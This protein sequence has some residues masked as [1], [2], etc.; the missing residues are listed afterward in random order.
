MMKSNRISR[1]LKHDQTL[2]AVVTAFGIVFRW[3]QYDILRYWKNQFVDLP[4]DSFYYF[5]IAKQIALGN[6][7]S[8]DGAHAT[9]GMH[10]L[11]LLLIAPFFATAPG[12]NF[13]DAIQRVVAFQLLL[14]AGLVW[15]IGDTIRLYL[16]NADP[17][18]RRSAF[19]IPALIYA[20]CSPFVNGLETTI[21]AL[22]LI[23]WLRHA[24][25]LTAHQPLR[26]WIVLGLLTG[27]LF[28]ARTDMVVVIL[29]VAL[30]ILIC[31]RREL[32]R[33]KSMT[34]AA[35]TLG[36]IAPWLIWNLIHFGT[37][38]QSSAEAVQL[39]AMRKYDVMYGPIGRYWQLLIEAIHNAP[40]PF[41]VTT[42]GFSAMTICFSAYLTRRNRDSGY[43]IFL[44]VLVGGILLLIVHSFFR[45]FIR[46]WYVQQL[47]PLFLIGFGVS[48][49]MNA[50]ISKV[51][52]VGRS[53]LA[54]VLI[55]GLTFY[56]RAHST[57]YRSQI[58]MAEVAQR[59]GSIFASGE[60][61]GAFNSG[62]YSFL[63]PR[64]DRLVNLDGVVNADVLPYLKHGNFGEYLRRDSI[65]YIVDFKGTIGGYLGLFDHNMLHDFT[66]ESE[67]ANELGDTMLLLHRKHTENRSQENAQP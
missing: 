61:V 41:I 60:K 17:T 19:L 34:A 25:L 22:F 32:D 15:L 51:R 37:I 44:L 12:H 4:D 24:R 40:K 63:T 10:P 47:I 2:L 27:L 58:A 55:V 11:W 46:E 29:P 38:L 28:L 7:I 67:V 54:V 49:G 65:E 16:S 62:M 50:G 23:L 42:L 35:I 13:F 30:W 26:F 43:T 36:V 52:V 48:I 20:V 9:N 45:G 66:L 21:T 8:I 1:W 53:L 14:D 33:G 57:N 6:G 18:N 39:F 31:Y 56:N 3:G 64:P 59:W 5:S